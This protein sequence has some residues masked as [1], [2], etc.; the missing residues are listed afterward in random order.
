MSRV[1][2]FA[3][4]IAN[5]F[6]KPAT[7]GE[8]FGFLADTFRWLPR[9]DDN[10][11]TGCGACSE[12]CSTG[13][14]TIKDIGMERT[15]SIDSWMCIYCGRCADV[16]PENA[17]ELNFEPKTDEERKAREELLARVGK[18]GEACSLCIRGLEGDPEAANNYVQQIS[19]AHGS[20][21]P[22]KTVDTT[23]PLQRCSVCGEAMPVTEKYLDVIK[24]RTLKNLQPDTAAVINKD[25][26]RYLRTCISC[27]R[28][29]SLEWGTHPRKF[30]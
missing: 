12:R 30:I 22:K 9:R 16:C 19:L 26:E 27:R 8:S 3:G 21:E 6:R 7:V 25:M 5:L 14:T 2:A 10:K 13:A 29:Y 15:V 17:L 24:E 23:L 18:N 28:K 11:C 4:L 1:Q 20:D